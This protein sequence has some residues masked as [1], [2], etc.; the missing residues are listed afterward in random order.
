MGNK[1]NGSY[2]TCSISIFEIAHYET[3]NSEIKP[4]ACYKHILLMES[5][6]ET[7]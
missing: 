3:S 1:I 6:L 5:W 2:A 4:A 7:S